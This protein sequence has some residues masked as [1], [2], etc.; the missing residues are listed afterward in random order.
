MAASLTRV[1]ASLV[2]ALSMALAAFAAHWRTPLWGALAPGPQL[3]S[4]YPALLFGIAMVMA[5]AAYL[6]GAMAASEALSRRHLLMAVVIQL[7]A[8]PAPPFTSTDAL[9]N[10]AYGRLA[11]L[12]HNPYETPPRMLPEG[13][14]YRRHLD[15]PDS[16][17]AWGPIALY[18]SAL[19]ARMDDQVS[20]L[21]VFKL[22]MLTVVLLSLFVAFRYSQG[23][24]PEEGCRAFFFLGCNPLLAWEL[25]GQAHNDALVVL[26]GVLFV[27]A[28]YVPNR[29]MAVLCVCAGVAAKYGLAPSLGLYWLLLRRQSLRRFALATLLAVVL[30]GVVWLPFLEGFSSLR[31]LWTEAFP[32]PAGVVNSLSSFAALAQ[33]LAGAQV[34]QVWSTGVLGITVILAVRYAMRAHTLTRVMT[35][36]LS[37]TLLY[38]LL[39]M[40]SYWPWYATWLLPLALAE[41]NRHQRLTVAVF[42]SLAPALYLTGVAG[43]LAILVVHGLALSLWLARGRAQRFEEGERLSG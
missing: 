5:A 12:G 6:L 2:I 14:S 21:V 36:S 34:L 30:F 25:S 37:F 1:R 28:A 41:D 17:D 22:T 8:A 16:L 39:A 32:R 24:P 7:C 3:V 15:W 27:W 31:G 40:A 42:S 20:A 38:Q 29:I 19:A 23:L 11:V 35:D 9:M 26:F 13:D 43:G 10:L 4:G 33:R 18:T